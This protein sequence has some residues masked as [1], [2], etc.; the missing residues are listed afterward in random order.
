MDKRGTMVYLPRSGQPTKV[1]PTALQQLIQEVIEEPRKTS[2]NC[3][4]QLRAE[5]MIQ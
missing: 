3:R 2:K 5:I 4:P 1:T